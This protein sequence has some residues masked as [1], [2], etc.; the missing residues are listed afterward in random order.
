MCH[1]RRV[2]NTY[3]RCGHVYDLPD[4]MIQCDERDCKFSSTH[5]STCVPPSCTSTC[6][7][8]RQ[9]PRQYNPHIDSFCPPCIQQ[10]RG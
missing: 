5:P 6:W 9:F 3:K 2:Q 4:V 10:G 8:Y 1:W 7:Q